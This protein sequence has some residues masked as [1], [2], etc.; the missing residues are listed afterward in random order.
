M[1]YYEPE[2]ANVIWHKTGEKG[3]WARCE[4]VKALS[5]AHDVLQRDYDTIVQAHD[6][7]QEQ[8]DRAMDVI[9]EVLCRSE[10]DI[11]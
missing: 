2:I 7:L 9:K 3:G 10:S 5:V 11:G 8:L 1:Q 4:D 6:K